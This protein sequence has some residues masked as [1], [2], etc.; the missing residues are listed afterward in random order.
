MGPRFCRNRPVRR[1]HLR[2]LPL[3]LAIAGAVRAEDSAPPTWAL[4]ANPATLPMFA[5]LPD[6][7]GATREAAP[8]D[9]TAD[10]LDVQ[11][12]ESTVFT[13]NV[14]LIHADQWLGTDKVTYGHET[15]RFVTEGQVRY[16]DKGVRLTA[17]QAAGDQKADTL[18]LKGVNYQ[19]N[20][21]LGNGVASEAVMHGQVGTLTEATYST[22]PPGQRQWEFSAS[23]IRVDDAKARGVAHNATLRIG[24]I[25][26]LWFPVISFPTDDRRRTGVLA[27]TVGRDDRNGLDLK[28]P[29]YFNLAP[30]YDATLAPHWFSKRGLMLEGEFR[31]LTGRSTGQF[32]GTF[33]PS[34][35][36]GFEDL[37][38]NPGKR[39]HGDRSYL[40]FHDYTT[41]N[42]HWYFATNL[43]NVSDK[44][45][46][47][48]FGDSIDATSISLLGSSAGVYGRGR[49]WSASL[50]A[51]SWQIASPLL[52]DGDEPYR[53]LPRLQASGSRPLGKHVEAGLGLEAV[54]FSHDSFF[55]A[56]PA[57]ATRYDGGNRLDVEPWV[58]FP[59]GGSAWF[60]TPQLAWRYTR[61][62]S[63]DGL[64]VDPLPTTPPRTPLPSSA[65]RSL[66]IASLDAGA[67]FERTMDWGGHK[68]VQT[69]EPRLYYLR[70]PYRDQDDL[71]LFD[72]RE[73]TFGW[74][75]LFRENRFGGGDRQSDANQLSLALTT[76]ILSAA[77][78]RE[79]LS[80]S[81]G[82]ITYFEAPRV[83]LAPPSAP[84]TNEDG[85]D[86]IANIDWQ[87]RDWWRVGVTQ[88]WDPDGRST[89]LS[90][91]RTQFRWANGGVLNAAYRFRRA[92][93]SQPPLE[94]TDL[95]FVIPVDTKWNLYGRWN[96]S[97]H[98]QQTIEALAGFEWNSCCVAVRLLG[99]QYIRGVG[100][101]ENLG[102]Y[103]EI[104]LNGLGSFGRDTA[105]LLDNAILGYAR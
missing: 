26:V 85:S 8:T 17:T 66:P 97:L 18:T 2:L 42:R 5:Q 34:D 61:Y 68:Y 28:V 92:L 99:R 56:N 40:S 39:L 33:L 57:S 49:F 3:C 81:I 48:D 54:R 53:R 103:L 98:D 4:C 27:P 21:Q 15:E 83:L 11:K 52:R 58:R 45:Y 70:V 77:D 46:F 47:S 43:N 91:V 79:K 65:S 30:N 55:P 102:L 76:R 62:D 64:P 63:L 84:L 38:E 24:K 87:V 78:G 31:Y 67:Y 25:P 10:L 86:W 36:L 14:E 69:L 71:P 104:E 89:D 96:Y 13:G 73:L 80:A 101:R 74:S 82:R 50:T 41:L 37:P 7:T 105:R 23:T 29:V 22:C 95:S 59:F 90:S 72:T 60:I 100:S 93:P 44:L 35:D 16:Q 75:S 12:S 88:Q 1:T 9:I 20:D 51:E 6:T 94:Q 32:N 19:F